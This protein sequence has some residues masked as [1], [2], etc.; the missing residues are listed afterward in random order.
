MCVCWP[1]SGFAAMECV[2]Q[3]IPL[4]SLCLPKLL[5]PRWL[6]ASLL[7]AYKCLKLDYNAVWL[8]VLCYLISCD[9]A[10]VCRGIKTAA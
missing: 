3:G 6:C 9:R 10:D 8:R 5:K 1:T 4:F 2:T 7:S